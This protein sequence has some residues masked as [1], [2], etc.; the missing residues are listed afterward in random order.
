M[1][2]LPYKVRMARMA[3]RC[4]ISRPGG[5]G[6]PADLATLESQSLLAYAQYL[7]E[8]GRGA[9]GEN[10]LKGYLADNPNLNP[11]QEVNFLYS[12]AN[13]ARGRGGSQSADRY[14]QEAQALQPPPPPPPV[15][16]IRIAEKL[17]EASTAA[18]QNRI[19]DAYRLTIDALD[20]AVQADDGQQIA[21]VV[22][23][24]ASM[25]ASHKEPAKAE[26]LYRRLFAVAETWK[27]NTMQ[28]L[29]TV[30]ARYVYFLRNQPEREGE[31]P[32]A[33]EQ[34]RRVLVEANG[35]DSGTLAEPLRM[36]IE[37]ARARSQWPQAE[38]SARE[39]LELQE[40]LSGNTSEPYLGDLQIAAR[41]YH[42]AGDYARALP[43]FRKAVA[44]ADLLA[45]PTTEWRRS[46]TR[47]ETA[48]ELALLG[49]FDEAETL[50]EEA[51]AMHQTM[52]APMVSME[53]QLEQIRQMK[54]MAAGT[55]RVEQ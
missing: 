14:F 4:G 19:P 8:R 25:L 34:H 36:S 15:G 42:A 5:P 3:A 22:P 38:E 32:A 55:R 21:W 44:L 46:E 27:T 7:G 29:V 2:N 13:L 53:G 51:V 41:L 52:R 11:Q 33:I 1:P 23:N 9:Q 54:W 28:P 50:G 10:L 16:Q 30:T 35:P 26:Q 20:T 17:Q 49:Q 6:F 47:I 48:F 37:L 40:S 43:L 24:I 39:L 31:V 12:L 45:T 18:T